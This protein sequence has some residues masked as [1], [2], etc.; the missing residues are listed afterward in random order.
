MG[1]GDDY[2][3]PLCHF[4]LDWPRDLQKATYTHDQHFVSQILHI[5][6]TLN[7]SCNVVK[8]ILGMQFIQI[9][10]RALFRWIQSYDIIHIP[11]MINCIIEV[12]I[13]DTKC[14]KGTKLASDSH[15]KSI[16]CLAHE[17][18]IMFSKM[19]L[20]IA[21]LKGVNCRQLCI[22]VEVSE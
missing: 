22:D 7:K 4:H 14:A 1:G 8:E 17:P 9:D 5:T 12:D 20:V 6:L 13:K 18:I 10:I 3:P 19:A 11:L 15:A 16:T 2:L 21:T